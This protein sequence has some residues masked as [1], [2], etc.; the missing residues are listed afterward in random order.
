[1]KFNLFSFSKG[2]STEA[3]PNDAPVKNDSTEV[4]NNSQDIRK[5]PLC[6]EPL[7]DGANYCGF[8]G[9]TNISAGETVPAFTSAVSASTEKAR[10]G[11]PANARATPTESAR[12]ENPKGESNRPTFRTGPQRSTAV[13]NVSDNAGA[14]DKDRKGGAF[15]PYKNLL[16]KNGKIVYARYIRHDGQT[17]VFED[18]DR[19]RYYISEKYCANFINV[20]ECNKWLWI[21]EWQEDGKKKNGFFVDKPDRNA[22]PREAELFRKNYK[23]GDIIKR[24]I[25]NRGDYH[26]NVSLS[27]NYHSKISGNE[28]PEGTRLDTFVKGEVYEFEIE[29]IETNAKGN[30]YTKLKLLGKVGTSQ[31]AVKFSQLPDTIK[32]HVYSNIME[33]LKEEKNGETKKNLEEAIGKELQPGSLENYIQQQYQQ[34]KQNHT[35]AAPRKNW[36][37]GA[38]YVS[39]DLDVKDDHGVPMQA[40]LIE[41]EKA[42]NKDEFRL[43]RIEQ[44][45]PGAEIEK[46]VYIEDWNNEV[47]QPLLE[48][49]LPEPESWGQ[50]CDGRKEN[51]VLENYIRYSFYKAWLDGDRY[52]YRQNGN[53]VFN[54]GLVDSG[55][56]DIYCYLKKNTNIKDPYQREWMIGGFYIWGSGKGKVLNS[57][58]SQKPEHPQYIRS[59]RLEDMFLDTSKIKSEDD[60]EVDYRHIM[61]DNM[62]RMPMKFLRDSLVHSKELCDMIDSRVAAKKIYKYILDDDE[63]TRELK[64]RLKSRVDEAVKRCR[65]DFRTAIPIYYP[66]INGLSFLLPLRLTLGSAEADVALVV[67]KLKNTGNYQGQTI[68]TMKMAYQNARLVFRPNSEWLTLKNAEQSSD[69]DDDDNDEDEGEE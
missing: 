4:N 40:T 42:K 8:C 65:W 38:V 12:E 32:C 51:Y 52:L 22:L 57:T 43:T 35:L 23:V 31:E 15:S 54:T 26:V 27:P 59:D 13:S 37:N 68:L 53:A 47:I 10:T 58:F 48:I 67:E 20:D 25:L 5:C 69:A 9:P 46:H 29:A 49:V 7:E 21:G 64:S 60:L 36:R 39:V 30:I 17:C 56:E 34:Q 63:L 44:V 28:L 14:A 24:P 11:S 19:K 1:M 41:N 33:N 6:G 18:A 45:R 16:E 66:K 62:K 2:R 55:Y 3:S 50:E 61:R